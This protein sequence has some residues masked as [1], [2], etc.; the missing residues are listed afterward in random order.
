MNRRAIALGLGTAAALVLCA[1]SALADQTI[2]AAP[3]DTFVTTDVSIAQ[4][5]RVSFHNG[6]VN[7]HNVTSTAKGS[8]G[9]PLFESKTADNNQTVPVEGTQYLTSGSYPFVCTIHP[10]M[11]GTLNV[12]SDGKP[13]PRP[14]RGG[15]T[16]GEDR[17]PP[18]LQMRVGALTISQLRRTRS[19]RVSV[20][21]DEPA[22]VVVRLQAGNTTIARATEDLRAGASSVP[23]TLLSTGEA[24]LRHARSLR[25]VAHG[26]ATDAAGNEDVAV[27]RR[28]LK[29]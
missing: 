25:L 11:R 23:L 17:T 27:A 1:P 4:G 26:A 2:S 14:G 18:T 8:D 22:T 29:G 24:G 9:R 12:T 3:V 19:V 7:I 13:L 16:V 15:D 21:L 5:E 28:T 6:D 10:N 20:T